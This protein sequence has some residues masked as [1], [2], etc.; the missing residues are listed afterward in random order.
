MKGKIEGFPQQ[1]LVE[2]DH[3]E[4]LDAEW[5][6]EVA[7]AD[8]DRKG[9]KDSDD[10]RLGQQSRFCSGAWRFPALEISKLPGAFEAA[11]F[12]IGVGLGAFPAHRFLTLPAAGSGRSIR[13]SET[14]EF[15]GHCY[16]LP[17]R[18]FLWFTTA[19]F[20]FLAWAESRVQSVIRSNANFLCRMI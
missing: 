4:E 17:P 8:E 16:H 6:V 7:A 18:E 19:R 3:L 5:D 15:P 1:K 11:E 20:Y 12:A 9:S 2:I 13:M 14:D 10:E